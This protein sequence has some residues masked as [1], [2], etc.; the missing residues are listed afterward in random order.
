MKMMLKDIFC[1]WLLPLVMFCLL[2]NMGWSQERAFK[3]LEKTFPFDNSGEVRIENKYGDITIYGWTQDQVQIAVDVE[4]SR[5][6]EA[7]AR[8]LLNR[9]RTDIVTAGSFIDIKT[10]IEEKDAG[11]LSQYLNKINR[12]ESNGGKLKINYTL[13]IP[14]KCNVTLHNSFGNIALHEWN[15]NVNAVLEYGDLTIGGE[16]RVADVDLKYGRLKAMALGYS[17]I[18]LINGAFDLEKGLNVKLTSSGSDIR[19]LEINALEI[20]SSKDQIYTEKIGKV[21]GDLRFSNLQ[22]EQLQQELDLR[23]R[24]SDLTVSH[25]LQPDPKIKLDQESSDININVSHTGVVFNAILEE[26]LLR[27]P[28]T[29]RN[30]E[31]RV[32]NK[33]DRIRNINAIYGKQAGGEISIKGKRGVVVIKEM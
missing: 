6:N 29:F 33:A 4:V 30:V 32:L 28:I 25:I 10:I 8:D 3:K 31:S 17:D 7:E 24:I 22:I 18:K 2:G 11:F 23:L 13:Y 14:E 26:G 27:L 5:R 21:T 15:G 9:I 16:V 1:N 19:I 12:Y 20:Y